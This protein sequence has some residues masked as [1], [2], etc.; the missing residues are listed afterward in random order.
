MASA[1]VRKDVSAGAKAPVHM[2]GGPSSGELK[3]GRG[4]RT[5]GSGTRMIL[6]SQDPGQTCLPR[7]LHPGLPKLGVNPGCTWG[8]LVEL[9]WGTQLPGPGCRGTDGG[10]TQAQGPRLG[11]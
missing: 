5:W 3:S 6:S 4:S 11:L 8:S 7:P 1:A 2:S 10:L 9:P